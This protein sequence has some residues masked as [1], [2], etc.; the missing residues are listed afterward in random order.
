ME[1]K[2]GTKSNRVALRTTLIYL[3]VG[4]IWI[5]TSDMVLLDLIQDPIL[6]TQIQTYKGFAFVFTSAALI[7]LLVRSFT[8]DME[9]SNIR[10][11]LAYDATLRSL[12]QAIELRDVDTQ[13]HAYRVTEFAL[14][15]CRSLGMPEQN[16]EVMH[17]GALLHDVGK[18]AIPDEILHKPQALS[19]T[20]WEQMRRHPQ[21]GYDLLA[22]IDYLEEAAQIPLCHHERWNGSGYPRGLRAEAI[23]YEAR[24]FAVADVWDA[25][26]S[27]RPYRP[28]WSA[29]DA[30]TYITD[31]SGTLFDPQ[32]VDAFI[33]LYQSQSL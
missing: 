15:L 5:L 14:K 9:Q 13:D 1:K 29:A 17:H 10:L 18:I 31:N 30:Y 12:V 19:D 23:P 26:T 32:V 24:I 20:E 4:L 11:S 7:F 25:L 22:S 28:A 16:L 21:L 8:L 6:L 33:E 2:L 27:D 3:I